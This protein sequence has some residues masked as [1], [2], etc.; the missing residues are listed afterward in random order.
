MKTKQIVIPK[1]ILE[2][3]NSIIKGEVESDHN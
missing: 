1:S 2:E 3:L